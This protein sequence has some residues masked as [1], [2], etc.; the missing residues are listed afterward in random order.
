M[1]DNTNNEKMFTIW[2]VAAH[3]IAVASVLAGVLT[4]NAIIG[5]IGVG[6]GIII[7]ISARQRYRVITHDERTLEI[8]RRAAS[9]AFSVFVIGLLAL[10]M[11]NRFVHPFIGAM[12]GE[13][14]GDWLGALAIL[15][16]YCY[17]GFYACY[18]WRM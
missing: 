7:L 15:M 17:L 12:S 2:R 18:R 13:A 16:L 4:S 14:A 5:A 8:S 11:L 6:I 9:A 1:S 3:V 10:Y